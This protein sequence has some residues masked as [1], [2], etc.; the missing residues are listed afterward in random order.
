MIFLR[1]RQSIFTIHAIINEH[2]HCCLTN[3]WYFNCNFLVD[4]GYRVIDPPLTCTMLSCKQAFVQW[5]HYYTN[6][7]TN[8]SIE[9]SLKLLSLMIWILLCKTW[10]LTCCIASNNLHV[11]ALRLLTSYWPNSDT[12]AHG[13]KPLR[14]K[15]PVIPLIPQNV[16]T[17]DGNADAKIIPEK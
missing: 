9:F 7:K 16:H 12:E 11:G 14:Y 13:L 15:H 10:H 5:F 1:F 17:G 2:A 4:H 8:I 3:A 6:D